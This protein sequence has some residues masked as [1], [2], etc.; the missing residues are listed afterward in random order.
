MV[1]DTQH[2]LALC[3]LLTGVILKGLTLRKFV[4][5]VLC[6]QVLYLWSDWFC[7]L[8]WQIDLIYMWEEFRNVHLLMTVLRWLCVVDRTLKSNYHCYSVQCMCVWLQCR[9]ERFDL[10]AGKCRCYFQSPSILFYIIIS[11]SVW[12]SH[13]LWMLN[14]WGRVRMGHVK[15][16]PCSGYQLAE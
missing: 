7:R 5:D 13:F 9:R 6:M 1:D 12:K 3:A 11:V 14:E 10:Y 16:I 4:S 15:N 8:T 2:V